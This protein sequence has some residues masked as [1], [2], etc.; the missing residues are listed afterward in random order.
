MT[1]LKILISVRTMFRSL[2]LGTYENLLQ[3]M[4][5]LTLDILQAE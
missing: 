5:S 1:L 3:L 2:F 4:V